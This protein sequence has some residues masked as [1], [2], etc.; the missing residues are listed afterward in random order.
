MGK[1]LTKDMV[2]VD[3][4]YIDN[5]DTGVMN[6]WPKYPP[7][8][9]NA[10]ED[11]FAEERAKASEI[12]KIFFEYEMIR[13]KRGKDLLAK[14]SALY[15]RELRVLQGEI[16]KKLLGEFGTMDE[17]DIDDDYWS[18]EDIGFKSKQTF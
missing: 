9:H 3:F 17:D 18:E 13:T 7:Y 15:V 11:E 1:H 2:Y 14:Y 4:A 16:K 6:I 12:A 10:E 8:I 5:R